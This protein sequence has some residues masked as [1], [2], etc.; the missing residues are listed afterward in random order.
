MMKKIFLQYSLFALGALVNKDISAQQSI[1]SNW[2]GSTRNYVRTWDAVAPETDPNNLMTRP[3]KDVKQVTQYVDGLGRPLQTVVKHGSMETGAAPTDMVSLNRY[4]NYGREAIINLPFAATTN[5]G[6]IKL[7]SPFQQQVN[8]Y[9]AQLAGQPFETNIGTG[10]LNWAYNTTEFEPSPLN[11]VK[12]TIAPGYGWASISN[13]IEI[14]YHFNTTTDAVRVWAVDNTGGGFGNYSSSGVYSADQLIKLKTKDENNKLVIEFKDKE[15]KVI[16][17]KVQLTAAMEGVYGSNHDGWLCTYYIYDDENNLRCVIQPEAVRLMSLGSNWNLSS[18]LSEQCFRYAYDKRGRLIM[19]KVPGA[20]EV[21]MVYDDRDRLVMTQDAKLRSQQKWMYTT[22]DNFN[23]PVSTGL[24]TDPGN[25]NNHGYHITQAEYSIAYPN[26]GAYSIEELT[27]SFYDNYTWLSLYG[28]PVAAGYN[29]SF[30]S[31]FQTGTAWPYPQTN[32]ATSNVIGMTTG[33][34][35]KVLG[36]TSTYL[37]T[38]SI[39]DEKGRVI[40]VKSTNNAGGTDIITTQYTWA[41]Q[42]LVT[43]HQQQ[44]TGS[45]AQTSVVVTQLSYDDLGRLVK[46]EKKVSNSLVNSGSMPAYKTIAQNEYDKLGQ[47]KN[48][49]LAPAYSVNGSNGLETLKYEYN[50]R[51]WMLGMNRDYLTD[52]TNPVA[53]HYFGFELGY[54]KVFNASGRNFTYVEYNGNINGMVWKSKGDQVRR[55][56]DFRYDAA[57]RLLKADFEQHNSGGSWGA[58]VMNYSIS[59]GNG[60]DP[61][62]GYDANGNIIRMKQ[63][64]WKLVGSVSTPIDQLEY[65]YHTLSNKLKKVTDNSSNTAKL[66]DFKDG[67]NTG[68]D[69]SYD[70]NG[71]LVVDENKQILSIEYNHLNLPQTI[72]VAPTAQHGPNG[73]RTIYYGYD[74]AGNKLHKTVVEMMGLGVWLNTT[75]MYIN[76]FVYET[77]DNAGPASVNNHVARLQFMPHEEG[78][79][80]FKPAAGTIAASLQYDYM[81]KDHLGNV[82]MVLTEEQQQDVYP[83]AT[84]EDATHNGGTAISIEDDFYTINAGNV[85]VQNNIPTY[86][87]N[88]GN[89]PYNNNTYSNVT[90]NSNKV[91]QL[92]ASVNTTQNKIGLGIA[93]KVMAGDNISIYGKSYHKKQGGDYTNSTNNLLVTDIINAFAGSSIVGG[94]GITGSQISGQSGFPSSMAGLIGN[95]PAQSTD[96]LKAS[97]NWI[98]LDEQFKYVSGGFDMVEEDKDGSGAYKE[99]NLSTIPAISIPK[100]GYI[101]VYCSNESQYNVFFDNLQVIHDRGAIL[102]ETHYYP[103]G[104]T[105]SGISSKALNRTAENKQKFNDGTEF[106]SKEFS[107]GSG[108]ELYETPYRG[109]DPQIGRFWQIDAMAD[110]YEDWSPYTFALNNPI[111]L[112]DPTGLEPECPDCPTGKLA[113]EKELQEVVVKATPKNN[114]KSNKWRGF[115][116]ANKHYDI[117]FVT[118]YLKDQGVNDN[119]LILFNKAWAGI[120]YRERYNKIKDAAWEAEEEIAIEAISWFLGGKFLQWGGKLIKWGYREYKLYQKLKKAKT[121]ASLGAG[122]TGVKKWLQNVG[123]LEREELIRNIES[124]GFKRMSPSSSPVSVYE[125]GGMRIRLDPPQPGTPFNHMHLEYGGNSYNI[126]L[127]PVHY[128]SPAAHIAIK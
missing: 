110:D 29:N 104:L 123:N 58:D 109:Y 82:R 52:N 64:G 128:K 124:V 91:Y 9:N 42:P 108:L 86:Q 89:P 7:S 6:N 30:D 106:S 62:D 65:S 33:N 4:D 100:N 3:V 12:K 127:N 37:Y 44:I 67:V 78:R 25:Y 114:W 101:Y 46:T 49:K 55:K 69:Y 59:M 97:I 99:H 2:D 24:L 45:G 76:G 79:I 27:K 51:G 105:M 38:I 14:N 19:K 17:K 54:N 74:A 103:F 83:A 92:N 95:H 43:V 70:V 31:H 39:Y 107:D 1:P 5:D 75:T 113:E 111:S 88:N 60:T 118:N 85:V 15:G 72:S 126:L 21:W 119:G 63:Y 68:D 56:Y 41:G 32:S 96:Q 40:Q 117:V 36:T 8:F 20:G 18:Y 98:I 84:L 16:L 11:R 22:Y 90:A 47:L 50:I 66:G 48:K 71:N 122:R 23:R 80:R 81:L 87:N 28:N 77:V 115:A 53:Q 73:S 116:D 120:G 61:F 26:T 57:N 102:E 35:V 93:L 112:N 125:R 10:Q 121:G 94:H 13:G 34:R